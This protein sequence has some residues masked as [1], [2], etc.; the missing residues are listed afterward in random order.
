G[1]QDCDDDG[2]PGP[3]APS[4]A[5][6]D[7]EHEQAAEER[8][9]WTDV[10]RGPPDGR[11]RTRLGPSPPRRVSGPSSER[12]A[13]CRPRLSAPA[14]RHGPRTPRSE[15]PRRSR[16]KWTPPP[17]A[18]GGTSRKSPIQSFPNPSCD[19]LT[20]F[21]GRPGGFDGCLHTCE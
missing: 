9:S 7:D 13:S 19:H 6:K 4:P 18:Y 16:H 8:G 5:R 17:A 10:H 20:T 3:N 14:G 11:R 15:C 21:Y 1:D 2:D 12:P